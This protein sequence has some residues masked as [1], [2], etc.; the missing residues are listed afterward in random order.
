MKITLLG[1][2]T[3]QGVP[4]I[5]C[6]CSVCR[7]INDKDKRLRSSAMIEWNNTRLIIDCGPDFRTQM[8][9]HQVDNIDGILFTHEHAD[10]VAGLDDIRPLFFNR[11]TPMPI[12]A[13]PRVIN[14]LQTRFGYIFTR[15]N[16]YP[17]APE[18]EIN[19][20]NEFKTFDINGLSITPLAVT[21]G[22]LPI[23]GYMFNHQIAYITDAKHLP[24]KTIEI[25]KNIDV[26]IVNALHHKK[27][28]MHFNLQKA[29]EIIKKVQ[30]KKAVLTH[31]SHHMGL[32]DDVSQT[33]PE[34]V[35]LG[36]DG[37]TICL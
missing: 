10:H 31:I 13:L 28:K 36:Y 4:V 15:E 32:Y 30:P 6:S 20:V 22:N 1:T 24:E 14:D 16:R 37:L 35:I 27:H 3:S 5:G 25:L 34:N 8:L 33:L 11:G 9:T 26:L 21:H 18:V 17:G 23:L 2:G 29:L 12:F 19:L 7:S